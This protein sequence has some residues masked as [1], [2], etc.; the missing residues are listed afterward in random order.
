MSTG[1]EHRYAGLTPKQCDREAMLLMTEGVNRRRTWE[2]IA[3]RLVTLKRVK[4]YAPCPANDC[5][6]VWNGGGGTINSEE[7]HG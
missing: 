1:Y 5:R 4:S 6:V 2:D 7:S 3:D